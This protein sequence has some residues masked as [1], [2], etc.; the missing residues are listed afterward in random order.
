MKFFGAVAHSYPREI[1]DKYPILVECLFETLD[2]GD[3][4]TLPVA[5]DT[6]GFI[7]NTIEG[8]LCL[9]SLGAYK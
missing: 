1:L 9:A 4:T 6:L 3:P 8:K 2:S 5:M 7:G